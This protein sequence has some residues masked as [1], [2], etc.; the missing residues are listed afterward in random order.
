MKRI[1]IAL[2]LLLLATPAVALTKK[3]KAIYH[4]GYQYGWLA[5]TCGQYVDGEITAAQ[6]RKDAK[7]TRDNRDL[8]PKIW[9][10]IVGAFNKGKGTM[11]D[12]CIRI[13]NDL[14]SDF[15]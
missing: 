8:P 15:L 7:D 10:A 6:F 12:P 1:A 3:E 14:N 9:Q 4:Y 2:P 11:I 5:N 13:V